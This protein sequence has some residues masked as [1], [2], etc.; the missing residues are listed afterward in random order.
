MRLSSFVLA[1]MGISIANGA[2]IG[3]KKCK[4]NLDCYYNGG[5]CGDDGMCGGVGAYCVDSTACIS[6]KCAKDTKTCLK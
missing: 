6:V 4:R 3:T 5:Q 1:L 2:F